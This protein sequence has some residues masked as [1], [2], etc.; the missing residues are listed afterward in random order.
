MGN[1]DI[2][3]T[4]YQ[5]WLLQVST[6]GKFPKMP[7]KSAKVLANT[8]A[9]IEISS[10]SLIGYSNT[11][12]LCCNLGNFYYFPNIFGSLAVKAMAFF[13]SSSSFIIKSLVD[14]GSFK[15]CVVCMVKHKYF[16]YSPLSWL[17]GSISSG[18]CRNFIICIIKPY[19]IHNI[20]V[21]HK[22]YCYFPIGLA[23][24]L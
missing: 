19:F 8:L 21:K 7:S 9:I 10:F 5:Y 2:G 14:H 15:Y 20:V 13:K 1:F 11:Y 12:Y 4:Q 3:I 17:V 16:H 6:F 24:W 18:I 23:R 22:C